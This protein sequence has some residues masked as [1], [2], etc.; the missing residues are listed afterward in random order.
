MGQLHLS[1]VGDLKEGTK[2][3]ELSPAEK[4]LYSALGSNR[5]TEN[6]FFKKYIFV[7]LKCQ[8]HESS[9]IK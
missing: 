9:V 1:E 5:L 4:I 2:V 6:Q 8:I 3:P 7:W